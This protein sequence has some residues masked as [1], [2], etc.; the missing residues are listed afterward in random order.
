[1]TS[2]PPSPVT[3]LAI[4][5]HNAIQQQSE[6]YGR[7]LAQLAI[8]NQQLRAQLAV[9]RKESKAEEPA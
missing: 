4:A 7:L 3:E 9:N 5:V 6:V 8:E 1:M 2:L